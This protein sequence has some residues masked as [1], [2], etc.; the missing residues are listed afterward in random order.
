[1]VTHHT[2]KAGVVLRCEGEK[3]AAQPQYCPPV[4]DLRPL[5]TFLHVRGALLQ[6]WIPPPVLCVCVW[7]GTIPAAIGRGAGYTLDR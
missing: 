1:M 2:V 7:G 3:N 4:L 6:T 5:I